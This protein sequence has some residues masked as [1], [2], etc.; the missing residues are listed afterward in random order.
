MRSK[1]ARPTTYYK[2]ERR[3]LN[4]SVFISSCFIQDVSSFVVILSHVI[5]AIC[6]IFPC[7][8]FALDVM[9]GETVV[10]SVKLLV[11]GLEL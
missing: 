10:V 1:H 11:D 2:Q 4:N 7:C 3:I 5:Q 9:L 8:D 6:L